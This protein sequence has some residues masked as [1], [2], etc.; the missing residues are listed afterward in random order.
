MI[1]AGF[2]D[3]TVRVYDQRMHRLR[4]LV[5]TWREHDHSPVVNLHM[6]RGGL[7]ELISCSENGVVKLWDAQNEVAIQ[8]VKTTRDAAVSVSVHEHAPVFAV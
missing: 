7:R 5:R 8:T 2:E 4:G 3:G 6:Q 1:C